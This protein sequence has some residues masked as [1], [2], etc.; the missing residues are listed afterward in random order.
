[1]YEVSVY[2][3]ISARD[4]YDDTDQSIS[5]PFVLLVSAGVESLCVS[6]CSMLSGEER[7]VVEFPSK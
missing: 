4:I 1:M 7:L 3:G 2:A 5:S 6:F